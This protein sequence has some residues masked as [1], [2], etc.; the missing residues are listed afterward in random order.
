LPL[1]PSKPDYRPENGAAQ[2]VEMNHNE[3]SLYDVENE[4]LLR[5]ICYTERLKPF[6]TITTGGQKYFR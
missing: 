6:Q 4:L 2:S 3:D 5:I 1:Q